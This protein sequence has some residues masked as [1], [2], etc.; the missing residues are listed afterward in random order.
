[1]IGK[2]RG[3][4]DEIGEDYVLLDVGGVGYLVFCSR[5]TLS[6]LPPAGSEAEVRL[7]IETHVREDHIHLY[8]FMAPYER[9]WF[10]LLTSVQ[11]VGTRMALAI[12]GV[13]PPSQLAQII[14]AA[15][16][17][18]LSRVSGVGLKL[19]ERI[20][21]E[22]KDKALKT[23]TGDFIPLAEPTPETPA[24]KTKKGKASAVSAMAALPSAPL[25]SASLLEDGISALTHLGYSRTEAWSAV[26]G[27]IKSAEGAPTLEEVIRDA[28]KTLMKG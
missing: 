7:F 4:V 9:E 12:L 23:P 2:L 14:M 25:A 10:L 11:R 22:L 17:R 24:S 3:K 19:A 20:V 21:T 28:L 16:A 8:G 15:D 6:N 26:Q 27:A 13:Y 1:M 18:M 5:L